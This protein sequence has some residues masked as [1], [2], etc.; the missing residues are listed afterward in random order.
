MDNYPPSR[1][2]LN[3]SLFQRKNVLRLPIFFESMQQAVSNYADYD[4]S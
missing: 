4:H 2:F 1:D 3:E